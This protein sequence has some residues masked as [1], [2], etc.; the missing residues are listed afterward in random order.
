GPF[1]R[2]GLLGAAFGQF[3]EPDV[4]PADHLLADVRT[5]QRGIERGAAATRRDAGPKDHD[6]ASMAA[7]THAMDAAKSLG[8]QVGARTSARD[9]AERAVAE[10]AVHRRR[11]DA[12]SVAGSA[13][14]RDVLAEVR[15]DVVRA[16]SH[17][18]LV[19]VDLVLGPHD[20]V[21]V[22]GDNGA[23][24]S[25]LVRAVLESMDRDL[26]QRVGLL[27]Q[28]ER[29]DP[30]RRAELL[31][32]DDRS[33]T[34]AVVDHLGVDPDRVLHSDDLS[35]GETRKLVLAELLV[36]PRPLVVLDEPTNHL[37][38]EAI[39]RLEEALVDYEGALLLVTHDRAL[40]AAT[41]TTTWLVSDGRVEVAPHADGRS[42]A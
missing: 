25:T 26:R 12:V 42:V 13:S 31:A 8:G 19:D 30:E 9:R 35:P 38:V 24:K 16:G 14:R 28:E 32:G 20:R 6:A 27:A 7:K 2:Q 22:H 10:T 33:R 37:D 21:R 1:D 36:R 41:T 3:G 4:E 17:P 11:G 5:R 15:R 23:G 40:A 29:V 18:V 34:L 39:E